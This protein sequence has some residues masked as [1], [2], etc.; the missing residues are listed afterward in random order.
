MRRSL[1]ASLE[2]SAALVGA[3]GD[4]EAVPALPT[5]PVTKPGDLW[6]LGQHRLLCGDARSDRDL[7][8]L[9]AGERAGMMYADPPYGVGVEGRTPARLRIKGD[10]A[11]EHAE[12][13]SSAFQAISDVLD[14]GAAIYISHPSR[15]QHLFEEAARSA[16]WI[17]RQQLVWIKDAFVLSHADFHWQHEPLIY[18]NTPVGGRFGRG[19]V[20]FYG[21]N[22]CSTVFEI[23]RPKASRLHPTCKPVE[24]VRRLMKTGSVT[25]DLVLDPFLG[26]G[27][28]LIASEELSRRGR[29]MELDPAYVD[30]AVRRWEA[31]TAKT[32]VREGDRDGH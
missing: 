27:T 28:S 12:L 26:S 32:A 6:V 9:M 4:P 18:A 15:A 29:F 19:G 23:P 7:A 25:G 20:G 2:A 31:F 14:E 24:L 16:G 10:S 5:E 22:A 1:F 3:A 30:V 13:I 17:V 11:G 21:G 8:R